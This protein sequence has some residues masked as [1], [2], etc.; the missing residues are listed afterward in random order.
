MT[1]DTGRSDAFIRSWVDDLLDSDLQAHADVH[2]FWATTSHRTCTA[3]SWRLR[4]AASHDGMYSRLQL[5][6]PLT[7]LGE[8]GRGRCLSD[9]GSASAR[10]CKLSAP[11]G[12]NLDAVLAGITPVMLTRRFPHLY[13]GSRSC[14]AGSRG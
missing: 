12:R 1:G 9:L 2:L 5:V 7:Q 3:T 14:Q 4:L 13:V 10:R 6:Q 11:L 8:F